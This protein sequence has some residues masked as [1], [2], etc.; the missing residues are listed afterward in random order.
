MLPKKDSVK[1]LQVCFLTKDVK[2][3]IMFLIF[4]VDKIMHI[5]ILF[6]IKESRNE[7]SNPN[8]SPQG[9]K[10]RTMER[11][12]K[13]NLEHGQ[14]VKS[15]SGSSY[16]N[17]KNNVYCFNFLTPKHSTSLNTFAQLNKKAQKLNKKI[18]SRHKSLKIN[19]KQLNIYK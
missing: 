13:I 2:F 1:D 5:H 8:T 4:K 14:A 15:F 6:V 17:P 3:L 10:E 16:R 7:N 11:W 19:I 18:Q 12:R 9:T